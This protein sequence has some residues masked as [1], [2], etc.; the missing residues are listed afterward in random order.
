MGL[1][2]TIDKYIGSNM[3][4]RQPFEA[5]SDDVRE[6][7]IEGLHIVKGDDG[8]S[9]L[10]LDDMNLCAANLS[11]LDFDNTSF[12]S[13]KADDANFSGSRFYWADFSGADLYAANFKFATSKYRVSFIDADLRSIRWSDADIRADFRGAK[14]DQNALRY[15]L[16]NKGRVLNNPI[17]NLLAII[18]FKCTGKIPKKLIAQ[19][20]ANKGKVA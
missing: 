9:N 17:K 20:A 3:S 18:E 14:L 4:E 6:A 1:T 11:G 8:L 19:L 2:L 7:V 12:R 13:V 5:K 16:G 10:V 15:A